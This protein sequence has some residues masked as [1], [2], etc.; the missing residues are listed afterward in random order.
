MAIYDPHKFVLLNQQKYFHL[1]LDGEE[2]NKLSS[3][4]AQLAKRDTKLKLES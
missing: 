4:S 2:Y 3:I 1:I